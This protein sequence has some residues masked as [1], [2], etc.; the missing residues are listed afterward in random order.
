MIISTAV[1]AAPHADDPFRLGHLVVALAKSWSHLIR[2]SA[3]NYHDVGVA[4]RSTEN[5][6][7]AILVVAGHGR[8]HH[9]NSTA[10]ETETEWPEGTVSSP[11]GDRVRGGTGNCD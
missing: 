1:S 6:T 2:N 10:G 7:K 9:F 5:D 11:G 4:R 3:G 8:V